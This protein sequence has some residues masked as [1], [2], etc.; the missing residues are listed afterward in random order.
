MRMPLS[1]LL[2]PLLVVPAAAA[3]FDQCFGTR[4]TLQSDDIDV[5]D[6]ARDC[7][8]TCDGEVAADMTRRGVYDQ[9]KGCRAQPLSLEDFRK[10]RGASPSYRVQSNVFLWDV[11]NPFPDRV[12]TKIEVLTQNMEL[13]DT[14][15]VG[16]GLAAPDSTAT[17][18]IPGF[19]EGYPAVRFTAKVTRM[20]ACPIK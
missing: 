6:A 13:Q 3:C 19:Y 17:F 18:V 8:E 16:T 7:R 9:V 4:I 15:Y 5:K 2:L 12:V 20:W 10:V 14:S 1:L 11:R